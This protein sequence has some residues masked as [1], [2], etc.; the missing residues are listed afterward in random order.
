MIFSWIPDLGSRI[1]NPAYES[2]KFFGL[3]N[4]IFCQLAQMFWGLFRN[5]IFQY[6]E[7]YGYKKVG[8]KFFPLLFVHVGSGIQDYTSRVHNTDLNIAV[9][10]LCF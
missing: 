6:C 5:K 4:F 8:Q 1:P 2:F 3:K 7:F 9:V 10:L